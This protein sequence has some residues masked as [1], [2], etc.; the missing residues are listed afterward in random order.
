MKE[1][2]ILYITFLKIGLFTIGGGLAMLPLIQRIVTEE[3]KWMSDGEMA[4]CF[5]VCQSLPGVVALNTATY[6]GKTRKGFGGAVAATLGVITPSFV[7]VILAATLLSAIGDNAYINGAFTG[8]KAAS[9]GLILY[10]AFK[11]GRQVIKGKFGLA[12]AIL[13]FS[14]IVLFQI[15]AVWAV[16]AGALAGLIH[17]KYTEKKEAV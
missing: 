12:I 7:I 11:M 15:T 16:C 13:S 3:K 4:D 8:V 9:C 10:A 2:L 14:M 5:A 17:M 1:Y 6:I